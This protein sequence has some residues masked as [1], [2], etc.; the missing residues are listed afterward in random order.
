MYLLSTLAIVY[1]H[2]VWSPHWKP[3]ALKRHTFSHV[4]THWITVEE[5]Q[6][7]ITSQMQDR[8]YTNKPLVENISQT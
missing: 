4:G 6:H 8:Q 5:E 2:L 1:E 3:L 7:S